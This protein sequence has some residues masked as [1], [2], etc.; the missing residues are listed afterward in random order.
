MSKRI[1]YIKMTIDWEDYDDV[2]DELIIEDSG[3]LDC[4]KEGI[5]IE[6]IKFNDKVDDD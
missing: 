4:L 6:Q 5:N 3:V 2:I 1:I